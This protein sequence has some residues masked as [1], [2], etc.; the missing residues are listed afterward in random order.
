MHEAT[1]LADDLAG[2]EPRTPDACYQF[3]VRAFTQQSIA[4]QTFYGPGGKAQPQDDLDTELNT[5]L[6]LYRK[7]VDQVQARVQQWYVQ[8]C[9]QP[10]RRIT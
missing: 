3:E 4:W 7:G 10:S 5:W 9:A 6:A 8:E 2:V 1:H